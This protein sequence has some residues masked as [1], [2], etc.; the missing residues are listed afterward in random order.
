M[1]LMFLLHMHIKNYKE[2]S[3]E[4]EQFIATLLLPPW[5]RQ[6]ILSVVTYFHFNYTRHIIST[7]VIQSAMV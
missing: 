7:R 6:T 5:E 1:P 4:R 3:L 2:R